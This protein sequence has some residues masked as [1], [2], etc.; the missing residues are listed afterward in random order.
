M[1]L[2][3]THIKQESPN[4]IS[5]V[6]TK[7]QDFFYY[8]GQYLDIKLP[9]NDPL[10]NTRAFT[11]SSS[12]TE[13]FLMITFKKGITP[14]KKHLENLK[15]GDEI[16]SSH[17]AG[18]FILDET[19]PAIFIAGGIGITPFRS[20]IK[21]AL[22][23]DFKKP[24]TLIYS[25]SNNNFT[26]KD[27][28]TQWQNHKSLK[29]QYTNTSQQSRLNGTYIAT[30]VAMCVNYIFYISGSENF[31]TEIKKHLVSLGIEGFNIRTDSF[32]GY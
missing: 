1:F 9:V 10:G 18:T 21:Y 22:D 8:P 32:D 26:F 13:D 19:E 15:I 3:I 31:I 14:F 12:P 28:L 6:F 16:E 17:P 24:I 30:I 25:N 20:M 29:L 7:T 11:I 5:L 4:A 23:Q 2:K 27:E